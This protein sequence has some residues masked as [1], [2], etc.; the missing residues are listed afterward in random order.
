[1]L[2]PRV[3]MYILY[4]CIYIMYIQKG[5]VASELIFFSFLF[6]VVFAFLSPDRGVF[7]VFR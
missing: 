2:I 3:Y 5:A 7:V 6:C 4:I 1:M